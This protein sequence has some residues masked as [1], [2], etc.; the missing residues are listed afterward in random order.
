MF[1]IFGEI[2]KG[3]FSWENIENV[4]EGRKNLGQGMPVL[5]HRLFEYTSK[6]ELVKRYGKQEAVNIFRSAGKLAGREFAM[7]VLDNTLPLNLF[8]A[9]LQEQLEIHKMGILRIEKLDEKVD[10]IVLTI[11]EELDCSGLHVTGK[12]LCNYDEGFIA[13]ILDI[14]T[15]NNYDVEEIDCWGTGA[16]VCRFKASIK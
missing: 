8:V 7:H 5:I 6:D 16:R 1:S 4:S 13:G 11:S 15:G 3:R 12:S 2:D 14:Y 10:E 9:Q